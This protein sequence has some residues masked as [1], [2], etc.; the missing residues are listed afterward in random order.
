MKK[1]LLSLMVVMSLVVS[2]TLGVTGCGSKSSD[3]D[4]KV[5]KVAFEC[6]YAPYNWTQESPEVGNGK[7]AVKIKNADGYEVELA[8]RYEKGRYV[9][10]ACG[11]HIKVSPAYISGSKKTFAFK[12]EPGVIPDFMKEYISD[13]VC[14][15]KCL[16]YIDDIQNISSM[17]QNE[18]D[19]EKM[20]DIFMDNFRYDRHFADKKNIIASIAG[21]IH[22]GK[23][24][25]NIAKIAEEV[26][27]NQRYLD[28]VFKE[29][30]G[31]SMKKYA[32]IIRIQ[33]AIYYLQ[34]SL[35]YEIYERLG[36]YDQA[37]FIK[38]F[39]KNTSLTPSRFERANSQY[40]IV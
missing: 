23:G 27:Y 34:N 36:Y 21:I 8:Q 29:A 32:E 20:V 22:K 24:N 17:L 33:K 7:Q 3:S 28:R 9:P 37:H 6:A 25:I 35:A 15:R 39:K 30:V 2:M 1:K 13:I 38:D 11:T 4:K 19:F 31:V 26:G 10:Y 14:D 5:L 16:A 40:K 12:F 18:D